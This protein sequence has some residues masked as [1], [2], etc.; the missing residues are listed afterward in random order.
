MTFSLPGK[1]LATLDALRASYHAG[2]RG[3][4]FGAKLEAWRQKMFHTFH[5]LQADT[6]F[7][8]VNPFS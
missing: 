1:Y 6:V 4:I 2:R 3:P 5:L 8:I 7:G